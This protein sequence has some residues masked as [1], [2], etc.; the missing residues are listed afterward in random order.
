[1]I[2]LPAGIHMYLRLATFR[3]LEMAVDKLSP[4]C[5]DGAG[6]GFLIGLSFGGLTWP[7]GNSPLVP[8]KGG[9][10]TG[11]R[12]KKMARGSDSNRLVWG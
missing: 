1:M 11:Y 8:R 3:H 10:I 7:A 4:R 6:G 12:W 9:K 5:P 2:R